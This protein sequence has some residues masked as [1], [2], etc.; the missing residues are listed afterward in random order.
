V[1]TGEGP[2]LSRRI[3]QDS[4]QAFQLIIQRQQQKSLCVTRN[5]DYVSS[6]SATENDHRQPAISH[7]HLI[8]PP[9]NASYEIVRTSRRAIFFHTYISAHS[10]ADDR[11]CSRKSM[12]QRNYLEEN[13]VGRLQRILCYVSTWQ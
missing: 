3:I 13:G 9:T 5:N 7:L 6:R 8:V 4:M 11:R 12:L 2:I 1:G 10:A